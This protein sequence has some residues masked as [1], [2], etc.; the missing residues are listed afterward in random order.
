M[1]INSRI[2]ESKFDWNVWIIRWQEYLCILVALYVIFAVAIPDYSWSLDGIS[3]SWKI[4]IIMMIIINN[5]IIIVYSLIVLP[6]QEAK[7]ILGE[8]KRQILIIM[9]K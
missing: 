8:R 7:P 2:S 4:I 3:E 6:K 9:V 5:N 1:V